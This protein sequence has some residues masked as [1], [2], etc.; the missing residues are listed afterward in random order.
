VDIPRYI[1]HLLPNYKW[2]EQRLMTVIEKRF[3][4]E[5]SLE[6]IKLFDLA[7]LKTEIMDMFGYKEKDFIGD[8]AFLKDVEP[9]SVPIYNWNPRKAEV[10]FLQ[11]YE[12]LN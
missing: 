11:L 7:M 1:K 10:K 8:R 4:V 12:Q 5:T 6:V 3:G 2:I 9:L